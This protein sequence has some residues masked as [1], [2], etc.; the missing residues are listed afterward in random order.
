MAVDAHITLLGPQRRPRLAQVVAGLGLADAR[1]ATINAGWREREPD[2]ALLSETLGGNTLNPRLWHR[3]QQVWDEDPE[4]AVADQRRRRVI[5]EMQELYLQ[6]L[7]YALSAL[8]TLLQHT[9]RHTGVLD[10]AVQDAEESVRRMDKRHLA[11]VEEAY[12][13]FWAQWKPHE[14]DS[15]ARAREQIAADLAQ[16][17]AVILTGGHV[18]V[19]MGAMHLF[20]IAP[21]LEAP[22]IAWGA[23]AMVLTDRVVLFHDR[24]AHGPAIAE[25]YGSGLGLVKKTVALP[26]PRERLDLGNTARMGLLARRF[27]PD[28]ALLLD[29]G[30]A[31]H[32]GY[33]GALPAGVPVL[34]STGHQQLLSAPNES[35]A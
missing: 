5:E 14:R 15:T 9:P 34:A 21:A 20:N 3:M 16:V 17:Q 10:E 29:T 7:D 13:E 12:A 26:S 8:S 18:G 1:F 22:I 32:I 25:V 33:D 28:K 2:D 11:R 23:G 30:V 24:A 6:R 27:A 4:L 31:V 19:L 35:A